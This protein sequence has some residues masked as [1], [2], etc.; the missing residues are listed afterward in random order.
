MCPAFDAATSYC[1]IYES[2]PLDC[3][4]YPLALMWNATR[5]EVVL[6][7][8]TKC[9][10]LDEQVPEHIRSHAERT[11]ERLRQPE[12]VD[13]LAAHPRMIG[14]FQAD[15]RIL[16]AL[17]H[18]TSAVMTRMGGQAIHPLTIEDV[19]RMAE[20]LIRS[21][22]IES[23]SLAAYSVPYHYMC[24]T[25]L[26]Y[27]WAEVGG[28]FYLFAHSPDGWFMPLP[29]LV[30]GEIREPLAQAFDLME[31]L[32]GASVVSRVENIGAAAAMSLQPGGYRLVQKDPDYLYRAAELASLGGAGFK[33][34]RTL[35]NR[36]ERL[37]GVT[38]EPYEA[39]DRNGCRALYEQ[40]Q[41]QKQKGL[42]DTFGR[43]LLEDA[44]SAHEIIWAHAPALAVSGT[45]LR[46]NGTIRAYTFGYWL[47]KKTW[48]VL[49]EVSD[50][51]MAGLAQYL[52][53]DTCRTAL[54]HGAE[55]INTMDDAGLAGLRSSKQAYRPITGIQ[56]FACYKA[57]A[58]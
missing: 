58:P 53:R 57:A 12:L 25:L 24:N 13:M 17:P 46:I 7:W 56:N 21:G 11:L 6:G 4:L 48:C 22:L 26:P 15:V 33:S 42:L 20:A 23:Q 52:F 50:R 49:L 27:W 38:V 41:E 55:F 35:C 45:V 2:R 5:T 39:A 3:Q 54:S 47:T 30:S 28:A 10:F 51:T 40:W 18:V 9:P 44:R 14:R 1:K 19:P 31:R 34:Q 43:L 29:P 36:I 8:D 16:T 32:N 37:G